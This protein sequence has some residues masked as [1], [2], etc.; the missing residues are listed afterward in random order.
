M[1]LEIPASV[2]QLR[3]LI[4]P[5]NTNNLGLVDNAIAMPSLCFCPPQNQ[6]PPSPTLLFMPFGN[7]STKSFKCDEESTALI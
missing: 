5:S 2:I 1:E 4:A 3:A 7:E 6:V